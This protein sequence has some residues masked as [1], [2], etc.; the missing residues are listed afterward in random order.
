MDENLEVLEKRATSNG[1]RYGKLVAIALGAAA[2]GGVGLLVYRRLRKPT[3]KDRLRG[4][5]IDSLREL[6]EEL[7]SRLKSLP[8]VTLTVNERPED[9]PGILENIMRRV[10]PAVVGTAST[11]L[12][13]R[14]TRPA[15]AE[16][17]PATA[18]D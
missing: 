6:A 15:A 2:V 16:G 18:S 5:S 17:E 7:T 8:S 1:V 11:A 9:E 3:L 4:M 14:I 10:A 12:L 13:H